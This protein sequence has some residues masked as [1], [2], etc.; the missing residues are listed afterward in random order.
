[1]RFSKGLQDLEAEVQELPR[2]A[3]LSLNPKP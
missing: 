2:F 3:E 1:M